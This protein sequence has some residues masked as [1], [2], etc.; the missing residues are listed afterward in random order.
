[1][2]KTEVPQDRNSAFAGER[3]AVYALDESGHY[4]TAPSTGW[5]VE[6]IVTGQAVAEYV[7]LAAEARQRARA[8]LSSPLEFHMYDRRLELPT[9]AAAT[10][11]WRWR[12]RRH[13]RPQ[14]F[15][16]LSASLLSRYANVLGITV[17]SLVSL[18]PAAQ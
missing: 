13:L 12:V 3:K 18:P 15:A 1:M 10:G 5:K 11:L 4:S 6:E 7:R 14:G 2:K 9:L 8:G 16:R 17:E